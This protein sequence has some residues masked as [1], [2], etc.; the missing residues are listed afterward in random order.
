MTLIA[1]VFPKIQIV[2]DL[3]TPMYKKPQF[4]TAFDSQTSKD[5][6]RQMCKKTRFRTPYDNQHVNVSQGLAK[7]ALP[8]FYQIFSSLWAKLTWKMSLLMICEILDHFLNKLTAD[9]NYC[10]HNSEIFVQ[11]SQL[12]LS[13]RQ[14]TFSQFFAPFLKFPLNFEHFEKK[15]DPH[16][17]CIFGKAHCER[18][19]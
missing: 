15:D 13:K 19:G 1:Y 17:L 5:V 16:S 6:V 4:R 9:D 8:H 10:F 14:K 7:S 18:R 3:V 11:P 12:Q 2:K